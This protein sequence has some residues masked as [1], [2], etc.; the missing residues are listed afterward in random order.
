MKTIKQRFIKLITLTLTL[1][2]MLPMLSGCSD[3]GQ[4]IKTF[5]GW[6]GEIIPV[7]SVEYTDD[8]IKL[9]Y[10][11]GYV[12]KLDKSEVLENALEYNV[13]PATNEAEVSLRG[14]QE[15]VLQTITIPSSN[16]VAIIKTNT[17]DTV[18]PFN[19][20]VKYTTS[21][22]EPSYYQVLWKK[23][24]TGES[25]INQYLRE[26]LTSVEIP[27]THEGY[28]VTSIGVYA[29]RDAVALELITI[30]DSVKSI[31][32]TAFG[33]CTALTSVEIPKNVSEIDQT[34]FDGCSSL[35]Q[36]KVAE[37]NADFSAI[38][39][40]L[41]NKKGSKLIRYAMGN[42][43][44]SY[45]APQSMVDLAKGAFM[46]AIYLE[47]ITIPSFGDASNLDEL[48]GISPIKKPTNVF[49]EYD[50]S[51]SSTEYSYSFSVVDPSQSGVFYATTIADGVLQSLIYGNAY[52]LENS[53]YALKKV[54]LTKITDLPDNAFSDWEQ[55]KEITLPHTLKSIGKKCFSN[56]LGL[57][58]IV[59]E[60]TENDWNAVQKPDDWD[61]STAGY[62]IAFCI[63]D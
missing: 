3:I 52:N 57:K 60:S 1:A 51:V 29:F 20:T 40:N 48:F 12:K 5:V 63:P 58:I 28:T 16:Q 23:Y 15:Y 62:T 7:K 19:A 25:F 59:F 38:D 34:A 14:N 53:E 39:G 13:N 46:G 6:G 45:T 36:F 55:L 30:P 41:Y 26:N 43:A 27:E 21:L 44:I 8:Q 10:E 4:K 54:I 9:K 33:G 32:K 18:V 56:C 61:L 22:T 11:D 42:K 24:D 2:M 37:A 31:G 47:K 49:V 35:V 17:A 50:Q